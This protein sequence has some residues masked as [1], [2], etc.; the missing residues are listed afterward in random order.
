VSVIT[1][2]REARSGTRDLAR[3]LAD[4]LGYRYVTR[5]EITAAANGRSGLDRTP[6]TAESE[7]RAPSWVEQ[8][9][10]QLSGE[11]E[12]YRAAL[13]AVV[14]EFAMQDNV[15]LVGYG[16][17][18]FLRDVRS[19]IRVFVVAPF[20][21]RVA[22]VAAE[23]RAETERARQLVE[24]QDRE[25][26]AF[27]RYL[28]GIDWLDPHNWDVVINVGRVDAAPAV[29]MLAAYAASLVRTEGEQVGLSRHALISRL[30]QV[31]LAV[32]DLGVERLRVTD[33]AGT[34]VLEGHA[35][36]QEDRH[37]AEALVR[38]NAPTAVLDNRIVVRPPSSA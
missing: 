38:A 21:D 9:G 28:F 13:E 16:A 31:L 3:L 10:E 2:S 17:G 33:D 30:E 24:Q 20:E 7:G 26:A 11:R 34:L 1:F 23:E 27:L 5:D 32:P 37:R 36:A 25:S 15:V 6:Q 19:V 4:R 18:L 12:A 29:E 14:T 8:L 22:R 35:L